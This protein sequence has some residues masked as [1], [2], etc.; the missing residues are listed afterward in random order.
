MEIN[1]IINFWGIDGDV[2]KLILLIYDGM[3]KCSESGGTNL[4]C[5]LDPDPYF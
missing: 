5:L 4:I 2:E 1:K 3:I